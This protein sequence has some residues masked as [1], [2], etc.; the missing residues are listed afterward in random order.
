MKITLVT[1]SVVAIALIAGKI[2][3]KPAESDPASPPLSRINSPSETAYVGDHRAQL[4]LP[5]LG[6]GADNEKK[7][8]F[9]VETVD[10]SDLLSENVAGDLST[11]QTVD[12]ISLFDQPI[13]ESDNNDVQ[14]SILSDL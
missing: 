5:E 14:P 8:S 10:G 1:V 3:L 13:S 4:D 12:N 2:W 7:F 11:R 6:I 9:A